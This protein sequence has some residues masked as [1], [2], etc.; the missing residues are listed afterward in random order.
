MALAWYKDYITNKIGNNILKQLGDAIPGATVSTNSENHGWVS[1]NCDKS[2]PIEAGYCSSDVNVWVN[3]NYVSIELDDG[4]DFI[5]RTTKTVRSP[6]SQQEL[7]E[8]VK[9]IYN[10]KCK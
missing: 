2:K 4:Y 1:Y 5:Y 6:N 9:N 10:C 3:G 8:L 7:T